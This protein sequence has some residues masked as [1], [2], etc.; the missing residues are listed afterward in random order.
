MD[1][2]KAKQEFTK[3][4][5]NYDLENQKIKR[6]FGHSFRVMERAGEIAKSLNLN[7]KEIELSKLIGLLHDIGR[8]EQARIYDTFSDSKSIDHGDLGVEILEKD[9]YIRKYIEE[10]KYDN[11]ILKAIKN[12]NKYTIEEGLTEKE[13]LYAK[14][15]RDAD[16]IDIFYEGAEIFWNE[17]EEIEEIEKSKATDIVIEE[18]KKNKLID[19]RKRITPLDDIVGFISFMFDLNFKYSIEVLKQEQYINRI[20]NRFNFDG[21]EIAK[22]QIEEVKKGSVLFFR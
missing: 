8:F 17:K 21:N 4:V 7:E 22:E 19:R 11:I 1:I 12:H 20:L 13:L 14:I 2:E 5:S 16:K 15:I 18:F 10:D 9:N 6:K 3:Y